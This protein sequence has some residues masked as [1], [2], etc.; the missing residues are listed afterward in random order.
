MTGDG[1][2]KIYGDRLLDSTLWLEPPDVRL[3]FLSMLAVADQDGVVDV[4]G[5][6]ALARKI[7]LPVDYVEPALARL[8]EPDPDSRSQSHEGRRVLARP[9]PDVGWVCVNYESYRE[10]RGRKTELARQRQ[11]RK[12]ERDAGRDERDCHVG[13]ASSASA[14]G[15]EAASETVDGPTLLEF[16][17]AWREL[18]HRS[19]FQDFVAGIG[20]TTGTEQQW[21]QD[22]RK[23]CGTV[24]EFRARVTARLAE[25]SKG[26]LLGQ[27]LLHWQRGPLQAPAGNP[28]GP[29]PAPTVDEYD[30]DAQP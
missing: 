28:T 30:A 8:M 4:P 13:H 23:M 6:R 12:R 25:D 5:I 1:F 11:A 18:T 26:F 9:R 16:A 17:K 27:T 20:N 3:V 14:S 19:E 22:V 10:F 15:S 2:V 21:L 24:A 7:N 29:Q